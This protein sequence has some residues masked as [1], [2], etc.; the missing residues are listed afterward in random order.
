MQMYEALCSL[1][2][3]HGEVQHMWLTVKAVDA[4][5][6]KEKI[7]E[8]AEMMGFKHLEFLEFGEAK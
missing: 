4:Q 8:S 6:A 1:Y 3:A 5:Q 2:D 7:H